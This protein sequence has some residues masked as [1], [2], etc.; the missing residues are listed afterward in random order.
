MFLTAQRYKA[1]EVLPWGLVDKV[2]SLESL[3]DEAMALAREI[4]E[5]APLALIATRATMRA[6][7]ADAVRKQTDHEAIEQGKLRVTKDYA[8]GVRSVAERRVGNFTGE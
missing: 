8:E 2:V 3:R 5:N 1:Q 6:G 4:A 7:L